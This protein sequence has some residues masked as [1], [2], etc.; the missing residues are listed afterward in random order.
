MPAPAVYG[1]WV[2]RAT[3]ARRL[4]PIAP[5]LRDNS[6]MLFAWT[7]APPGD[8]TLSLLATGADQK[9]VTLSFATSDRGPV[10]ALD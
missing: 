2:G 1:L 9:R 3:S 8:Q 7:D 4:R 6:S 5:L 10:L